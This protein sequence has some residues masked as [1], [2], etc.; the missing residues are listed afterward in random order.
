M[1]DFY[2]TQ[3]QHFSPHQISSNSLTKKKTMVLLKACNIKLFYN[4]NARIFVH[5]NLSKSRGC[6]FSCVRPIYERVVSDLGP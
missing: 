5:G 2:E 1:K 6:I 3:L 4:G